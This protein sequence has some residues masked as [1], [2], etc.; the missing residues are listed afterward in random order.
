MAVQTQPHNPAHIKRRV[1]AVL[2]RQRFADILWGLTR[3]ALPC[4]LVLAAVA[5]VVARLG[6]LPISLAWVG[7]TPLL[8]VLGWAWFRP[9][10]QRAA[11]RVLDQ[12]Y[13]LKDMLGNA[14]E[15]AAGK[16]R[17]PKHA[18]QAEMIALLVAE[19]DGRASTIDPRPSVPLSLPRVSSRELVAAALFATALLVPLPH[20]D[21]AD[22][23]DQN[24]PSAT[25][26]TN[27]AAAKP[28]DMALAEP[29]REDLRSL[30]KGD[31]QAAQVADAV[32]DILDAYAKGEL[33]RE[34]AYAQLEQLEDLLQT[35][36]DEFE[37]SLD[38]DP[39]LLA[40]GMRRLA[41]ALEQEE[42]TEEAGRALG[43]GKS[44]KLE[45]E[46]QK[47]AQKAEEGG[48]EAERALKRAMEAA[49]RALK[50]TAEQKTGTSDQLS[51]AERRLKR[52]KKQPHPDSKEQ[53]RRLKKLQ[54][55]VEQLR[56]QQ[57]RE[58]KARDRLEKLR[59]Q[60][61]QAG[62]RGKGQQGAQKRRDSL[63]KLSRGAS[64]AQ[65]KARKARR[66][67]QARDNYEEARTFI[68]RSG[69]N[70][71]KQG[72]RK[73]QM[74]RFSK[75]A[76]GKKGKDGKNGKNGKKGKKGP[77]LL[78]EGDVGDGEPDEMLL[79]DGQDGQGGQGEG[80][81]DGDG[82]S[83]FV[84]ASPSDNYGDGSTDPLGEASDMKV[85]HRNVR[86]NPEHGRGAT[87]AEVISTASQDGFAT[88]SYADVY[89]DYKSFAQSALDTEALPAAERRR[90][91]RYFQ[92]IQPR[93]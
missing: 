30:K 3:V 89:K 90:V 81:G 54:K 67:G 84:A 37:A 26:Q 85:R 59:R 28:V 18:A 4:G 55:R 19:A 79:M 58:Q 62:Q 75:A 77:T 21:P 15:F 50:K 29:L 51:E 82:G 57:E 10:S 11:A 86:F 45:E 6:D 76:K 12:H 65:N 43:N 14:L 24:D 71:N 33:D 72:K 7:I 9:R 49:E 88:T 31:D 25:E 27:E 60:A 63:Q 32:L 41:E 83:E 36:E 87:R 69:K 35:A 38:E 91:K 34:A 5:I 73:Q 56:R 80:Q 17:G 1:D 40:E 2:R 68:R 44:D 61:Q 48:D 42:L 23:V 93:R 46:L 78:V 52:Q 8:G 66:L 13:D 92:L 20:D 74:K 22:A 53:E 39:A 47:A 64:G 70:G 16:V